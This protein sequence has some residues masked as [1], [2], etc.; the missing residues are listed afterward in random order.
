MQ[1]A[2]DKVK[3]MRGTKRSKSQGASKRAKVSTASAS[4]KAAVAKEVVKQKA[5]DMGYKDDV[6]ATADTVYTV[7]G[8]GSVILLP[9]PAQ[10][11]AVTERVGKK[12]LWA[13]VQLRGK[14]FGLTNTSACRGFIAVIYD[15]DPGGSLPA[16]NDIFQRGATDGSAL[17]SLSMLNPAS[18][19]RFS[20]VMR[21]DFIVTAGGSDNFGINIEE[22]VDLKKRECVF[23]GATG[24]YGDIQKGALLLVFG[25]DKNAATENFGLVVNR[26]TRFI[27]A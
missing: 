10:G 17:A 22:W 18:S 16:F 20:V 7:D 8:S 5:K 11:A 14:A 1:Y 27:D 3:K 9:T 15:R 6:T 24:G 26:R 12:M 13:S 19:T 25:S 4:F 2:Q 21:R 23:K